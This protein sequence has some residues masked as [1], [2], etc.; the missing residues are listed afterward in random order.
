MYLVC[1]FQFRLPLILF[2]HIRFFPVVMHT[3]HDDHSLHAYTPEGS[4]QVHN[5]CYFES[6]KGNNF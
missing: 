6:A 5:C 1:A 4:L 3:S 2:H